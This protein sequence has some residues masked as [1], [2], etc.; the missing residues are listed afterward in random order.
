MNEFMYDD[1]ERMPPLGRPPR[2]P[3]PAVDRPAP[4]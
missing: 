2:P 3:A 1:D 4:A